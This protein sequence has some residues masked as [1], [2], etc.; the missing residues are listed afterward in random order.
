MTQDVLVAVVGPDFEEFMFR[1]V[2][3][4]DHFFH[5][6]L[7]VVQLKAERS[8]VRLVSGVTLDVQPHGLHYRLPSL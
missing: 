1:A 6:I 5:E 3:L 8:L 7:A 2:P 4:I